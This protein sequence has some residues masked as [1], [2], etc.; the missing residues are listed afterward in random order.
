MIQ[1]TGTPTNDD[2]NVDLER[3][4]ELVVRCQAGDPAAFAALYTRY[5]AR[6]FRFC[7]RRLHDRQ[8]AEDITQESFV[9]AWRALPRFSGDRRFYPWLTVIAKNLCT[10]AL[11]R[12]AR[13]SPDVEVDVGGTA[14]HEVDHRQTTEELVIAAVDGE[15]VHRALGRLTARHRRVLELREGSEWSY[16][17]IARFEGVEV[18]A[19]ETLVW[20]A[21]QA[22]KREFETVSGSAPSLGVFALVGAGISRRWRTLV[23]RH[24]G[25]LHPGGFR[26]RDA[27]M[28]L[29]VTSAV[30]TSAA[31][32]SIAVTSAATPPAVVATSTDRPNLPT[33][34]P[35]SSPVA[36]LA[37]SGSGGRVSDTAA[38]VSTDRTSTTGSSPTA[39]GAGVADVTRAAS[40]GSATGVGAGAAGPVPAGVAAPGL[41][42][43]VP[44]PIRTDVPVVSTVV[45][46]ATSVITSLATPVSTAV[47]VPAPAPGLTTIVPVVIG[48]AQGVLAPAGNG[49]GATSTPSPGPLGGL[50]G[51]P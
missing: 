47:P 50:P 1:Y 26:L 12:R 40:A 44:T 13:T 10:D 37:A 49:T 35:R 29:V 22:L 30:A 20:R 42:V 2:G 15:L 32:P 8:E 25:V 3:D 23:A 48:A 33:T 45:P 16:K 11:R 6:L 9:K 43:S 5:E 31:L 36:G 46:A 39:T 14:D 51:A 24:G 41:P 4:R 21:R 7:L 19:V 27:A 18:S 38:R 28:A 34:G 17:D